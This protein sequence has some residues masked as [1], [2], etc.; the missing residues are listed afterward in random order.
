M[1]ALRF[2]QQPPHPRG[3]G[4]VL[5]A[6]DAEP[7][8]Q[9]EAAH[10][11]RRRR[12]ALRHR[13]RP[14]DSRWHGGAVVRERGTRTA[15]DRRGD[16]GASRKTRLRLLVPDESSGGLRARAAHHRDRARRARPCLLHQFRLGI[17][18]HRAQDRA[19]LSPRAWRGQPHPLHLARQ[20]LSRHGLGRPLR[21]RH[22]PPPQGFRSAAAG[23]RSPPAYA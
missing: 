18:R 10:L 1:S 13:R 7:A 17:G 15:A 8:I 16:S 11:R 12:H 14:A 3:H 22:R 9:G 21:E 19:R 5:A 2:L 23:G 4:A 6:D 20:G